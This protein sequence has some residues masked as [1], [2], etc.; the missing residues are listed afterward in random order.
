MH[1][2]IELLVRSRI[3]QIAD[4][5]RF[6]SEESTEANDDVAREVDEIAKQLPA[7]TLDLAEDIEEPAGIV[8]LWVPQLRMPSDLYSAY[9]KGFASLSSRSAAAAAVDLAVLDLPVGLDKRQFEVLVGHRLRNQPLIQSID[10]HLNRPRR[11]GEVR[12]KLSQL[13][14]YDRAQA[15]D[16]WQT[17]M[18]WMMEFLPDRYTRDVHRHSEIMS[19]KTVTE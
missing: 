5:E 1:S 19:R 13:T 14:G 7:P 8:D 2:N 6:L 16:A 9:S 3:D 11:F 4:V 10:Q 15:D 17:V 12:E 18:R